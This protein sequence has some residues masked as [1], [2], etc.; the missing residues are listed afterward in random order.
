LGGLNLY[1]LAWNDP[2]DRTDPEGL[3]PMDKFGKL[4]DAGKDA[5]CYAKKH[6][7]RINGEHSEQAA[8]IFQDKDGKFY[9]N[10]PQHGDSDLP[11]KSS[12]DYK[13]KSDDD[14]LAGH[15]HDHIFKRRRGFF[16]QKG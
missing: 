9:Y 12:P 1:R 5:A 2:L 10:Y 13:L 8:A 7:L 11:G 15:F 3:D 6:P 4:D 14:K 16:Q